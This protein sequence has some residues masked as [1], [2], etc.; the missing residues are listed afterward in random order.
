MFAPRLSFSRRLRGTSARAIGAAK[1]KQRIRAIVL[2]R[3][4]SLSPV[5]TSLT[6]NGANT[7]LS[8]GFAGKRLPHQQREG[9]I[10]TRWIVL[11][12]VLSAF[13]AGGIAGYL[14]LN[15]PKPLPPPV[16]VVPPPVQAPAGPPPF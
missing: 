8:T 2:V 15:R 4:I 16:V 10:R 14:F 5:N 6:S 13:A 9:M 1:S 11:S 7:F 3:V 12:L